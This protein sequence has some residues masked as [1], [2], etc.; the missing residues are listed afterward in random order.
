MK[1]VLQVS[2]SYVIA[3][4]TAGIEIFVEYFDFVYYC[5]K[6][7]ENRSSTRKSE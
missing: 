3:Q 7:R 1:D 6:Y 5:S 2:R 4:V